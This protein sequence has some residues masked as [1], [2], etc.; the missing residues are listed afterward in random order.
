[1]PELGHKVEVILDS[2]IQTGSKVNIKIQLY[3]STFQ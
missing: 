3:T 1:M 2:L